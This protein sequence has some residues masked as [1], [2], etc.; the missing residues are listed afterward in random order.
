VGAILLAPV[1]PSYV[2]PPLQFYCYQYEYASPKYCAAYQGLFALA[3]LLEEYGGVLT[4]LATVA[5]AWF[6]FT[7]RRSTDRLWEAGEGQLRVAKDSADAAKASSEAL[8]RMERAYL[9]L[10]VVVAHLGGKGVDHRVSVQFHFKNYGRTPALVTDVLAALQVCP[11]GC[12]G[13]DAESFI[14]GD[15]P[16]GLAISAGEDAD[17]G[18]KA[19][20]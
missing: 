15:M 11:S 16:A 18:T 12:P 20:Y 19:L 7:L 6:T 1:P 2:P 17:A 5:I 8:A 10:S 3:E 13:E 4:A 9:F 14:G